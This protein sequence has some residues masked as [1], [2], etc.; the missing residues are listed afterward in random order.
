M[1]ILNSSIILIINVIMGII[2]IINI[3]IIMNIMNIAYC[4]LPISPKHL[5]SQRRYVRG[6]TAL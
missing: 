5:G 4:L 1:I 2:G 3:R 6:K